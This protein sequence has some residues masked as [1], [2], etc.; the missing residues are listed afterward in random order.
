[1]TRLDDDLARITGW[2]SQVGT[3]EDDLV[4]LQL[5]GNVAVGGVDRHFGQRPARASCDVDRQR[6][7]EKWQRHSRGHGICGSRRLNDDPTDEHGPQHGGGHPYHMSFHPN[8][9]PK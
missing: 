5:G 8:E 3:F 9:P 4:G 2:V 7:A 1:V 6:R